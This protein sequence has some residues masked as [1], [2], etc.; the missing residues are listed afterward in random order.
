MGSR[1]FDGPDGAH[2][3]DRAGPLNGPFTKPIDVRWAAQTGPQWYVTPTLN[4]CFG[5]APSAPRPPLGRSVWVKEETLE[6]QNKH[7]LIPTKNHEAV[8]RKLCL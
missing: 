8:I 5:N 4:Y 3:A 7:W 6:V 2:Q 1:H